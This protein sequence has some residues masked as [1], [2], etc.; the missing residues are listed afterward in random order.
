MDS[1][2]KIMDV[3]NAEHYHWGDACDGWHLVN[4]E[5]L[6]VI[7]ERMPSSTKEHLHFHSK[8]QQFFYILL[9]TATFEIDGT[10]YILEPN[11]GIHIHPGVIHRISNDGEVD[12]EFLV[13]SNPKS[14]GDR[15][16]VGGKI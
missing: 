9:G 11:R 13:I 12:L 16:D 10:E 15:I 8:A 14:H 5:T 1:K 4:S 6:S 2:T 3:S 7:K